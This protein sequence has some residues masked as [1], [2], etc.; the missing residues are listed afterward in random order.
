MLGLRFTACL[1]LVVAAGC[2]SVDAPVGVADSA[3]SSCND[4][5]DCSVPGGSGACVGVTCNGHHCE[6][7]TDATA[8][9]TG[10]D[11]LDTTFADCVVGGGCSTVPCKIADATHAL[12]FCDFDDTTTMNRCQCTTA[13]VGTDCTANSCQKNASCQAGT[14]TYEAKAPIGGPCCNAPTDCISSGTGVDCS[15]NICACKGSKKFCN[16]AAAGDG[17]CV[18][19]AGCC[20]DTDCPAGNGC[21]VRTCSIAGA[22]G[23]ASNGNPG[24]CDMDADCGGTA[25]CANNTCTCG[26]GEKFC[27]GAS[28]GAGL[29]I[30]TTGCCTV[31]DCAAHTD[32]SV[33]CTNNACVYTCDSGFHDCSGTCKSSS[34]VDSC[35]TMCTSCPT[36]NACQT[37]AC[38]GGA[39]GF[40]AGG[41][42]PCCN[43]T[44][45]CTPANAC[46][47]ATACTA[48]M[49]VFG[50]TGASG[51]CNSA[52]DCPKP[53]EPCLQAACVANQCAT[54]PILGCSDDGGTAI[55]MTTAAADAATPAPDLSAAL[56]LSGGGGC[57]FAGAL[58]AS[59]TSAT[60][61][62]SAASATSASSSSPSSRALFFF[63][64]ALGLLALRRRRA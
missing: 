28:A 55:D 20:L 21:Q 49:C 7:T 60:S 15:N 13:T 6:Y 16:G 14:C 61:A 46:Q 41:A 36:G 26:A 33:A 3:L 53:S 27:T 32:A 37:P 42:S 34:S 24:C 59:A 38:T 5:N 62:T 39:C 9:P 11:P 29:C 12:P 47:Q 43:A 45:D 52:S 64:V 30:P 63:A 56:S 1:A 18:A 17:R 51:C 57:A 19:T 40:V 8:C 48:N 50:S 22:C 25:T 54:S 35:G 31:S 44:G 2:G 58:P 10:C 4:V 23:F